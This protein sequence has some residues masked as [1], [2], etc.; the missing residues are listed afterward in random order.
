MDC[1]CL[2]L[3]A[4]ADSCW[5]SEC[6]ISSR[7]AVCEGMLLLELIQTKALNRRALPTGCV[8]LYLS[9]EIYY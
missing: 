5:N 9:E 4:F 1:A 2:F 6:S 3:K 8:C 7:I